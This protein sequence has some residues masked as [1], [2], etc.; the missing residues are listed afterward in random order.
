MDGIVPPGKVLAE[1]LDALELTEYALSKGIHVQ[2]TRICH[3][4][5]GKRSITLDT[6]VRL[7]RY[8]KMPELYWLNLQNEYDLSISNKD[9]YANIVPYQKLFK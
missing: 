8:F 3:I 7:G 2:Q 1:F 4:I 6:S 5:Q 9:M